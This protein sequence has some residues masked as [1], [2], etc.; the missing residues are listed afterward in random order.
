ML[1]T[2]ASHFDLSVAGL[3]HDKSLKENDDVFIPTLRVANL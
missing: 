3:S 1:K 2:K